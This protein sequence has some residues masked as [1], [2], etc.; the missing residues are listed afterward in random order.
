MALRPT[1]DEVRGM[2]DFAQV[3]RWSFSLSVPPRGIA[4]PPDIAELNLRCESTDMPKK[5]GQSTELNIRGHK[6]RRPGIHTPNVPI[7][8]TFVETVDN[9]I[10]QFIKDWR[11]LCWQTGSGVQAAHSDLIATVD[12]ILLDNNDLPRW[13]YTLKGAFI[14]DF[15]PGNTLDGSTS[16]FLKPQIMLS[17]DDFDDGPVVG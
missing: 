17:Y 15:S 6:I 14:E 9:K 11:E 3:F 1:M 5:T 10:M 8:I 13:K 2:G 7:T 12:I 4:A 16:D